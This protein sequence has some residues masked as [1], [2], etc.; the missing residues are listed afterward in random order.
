[1]GSLHKNSVPYAVEDSCYAKCDMGRLC[2]CCVNLLH[3]DFDDDPLDQI[4]AQ[5]T[6]LPPGRDSRFVLNPDGNLCYTRPATEGMVVGDEYFS[7]SYRVIDSPGDKSVPAPINFR[8]QTSDPS[9]PS[10]SPSASTFNPAPASSSPVPVPASSSPVPVPASSSPLPVPASPSRSRAPSRDAEDDDDFVFPSPSRSPFVPANDDD[11]ETFSATT[12]SYFS[13]VEFSSQFNDDD[14]E[15][16]SSASSGSIVLP[17]AALL[18]PL[19]AIL[20]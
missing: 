17:L 4:N 11:D 6:A 2:T 12:Y 1:M 13:P 18:I 16:F 7:A 15:S 3:N 8:L 10:P 5:L 20:V 14:D 19:V 9:A